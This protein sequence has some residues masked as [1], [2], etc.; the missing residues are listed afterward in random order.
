MPDST[1]SLKRWFSSVDQGW[2]LRK[3][4]FI[5]VPP[6]AEPALMGKVP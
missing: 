1:I 5:Y 3:A 6:R 2:P 4:A